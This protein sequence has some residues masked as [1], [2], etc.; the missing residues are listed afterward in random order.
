MPKIPDYPNHPYV[1]E[2]KAGKKL[3]CTCGLSNRPPYCD[4]SHKN[5]PDKPILVEIEEDRRVAWCG[6]RKSKELPFCD[7]SHAYL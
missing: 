6:C 7:G 3:Y 5:T 1:I 4:G 2:E